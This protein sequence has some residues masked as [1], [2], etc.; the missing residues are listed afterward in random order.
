M[1]RN[2]DVVFDVDR[3]RLNYRRRSTLTTS[4][5][6][7][8]DIAFTTGRGRAQT[9]LP[10]DTSGQYGAPQA[11]QTWP[12]TV[13]PGSGSS[14]ATSVQFVHSSAAGSPT[15]R[16]GRSKKK[17][18]GAGASVPPSY[19]RLHQ[20]PP[21]QP[22][23]QHWPVARSLLALLTDLSFHPRT[24]L[25]LIYLLFIWLPP[26]LFRAEGELLSQEAVMWS[27]VSCHH[28]HTNQLVAVNKSSK[29]L[30]PNL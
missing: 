29:H 14:S 12:G 15:K 19:S 8:I 16:S 11:Q 17:R 7:S 23:P 22:P 5:S 24:A 10:P 2:F 4:I 25:R 20:Q 28:Q 9:M 26:S 21:P 13:Q 27:G 30:K 1:L 6:T 3:Y 18:R